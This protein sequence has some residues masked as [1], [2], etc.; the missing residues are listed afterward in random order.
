[1]V[2]VASFTAVALSI[3]IIRAWAYAP[4]PNLHPIE[5]YANQQSVKPGEI[6][7]F[8]ASLP[9]NTD[10]SQRTTYTVQYFRY[11]AAGNEQPTSVLGP[12]QQT[13]GINQAYTPSAYLY[14]AAWTPSFDLSIPTDWPSGIYAAQLTDTAETNPELKTAWVTFIVRSSSGS[15]KP[16]AF[17]AGT[18]TYHAY[19]FWPGEAGNDDS[20]SFYANCSGQNARMEVSFLRPAPSAMPVSTFANC[21]PVDQNVSYARNNWKYLENVRT[22]HLAAADV[23]IARWLEKHQYGYSMLTDWDI[24]QDYAADKK[25]D[26]LNPAVT[27]VLIIGS[28][29]EYW[30]Q[31]MYDALTQYVD[32]GGNLVVLGGNT[33]YWRVALS[34]DPATGNRTIEKGANWSSADK[35]KLL[36]IG[37]YNG[38]HSYCYSNLGQFSTS[39]WAYTTPQA[40][41]TGVYMGGSGEMKTPANECTSTGNRATAIGWEL[42]YANL[43][44]ARN[45]VRLAGLDAVQDKSDVFYFQRPSAGSVFV[46][47]SITFGQSLMYDANNGGVMTKL[48]QNILARMNKRTFSDFTAADPGFPNSAGK[49]DLLVRRPNEDALRIYRGLGNDNVLPGGQVLAQTGW[50]GYNLLLPIGD[51]DSDG[52]ADVLA[53]DTSGNMRLHRGNGAGGF[54]AN[55][56]QIIDTGWGTGTFNSIVAP[57]DWNGDGHPDLLARKLDGSLHLYRG[58]GKGGFY[59]GG[60]QIATGMNGLTLVAPGDFDYNASGSLVRTPGKPDLIGRVDATGDLRLYHGNGQGFAGAYDVINRGWNGITLISAGDFSGD[61]HPD[62]LGCV[63]GTSE[64]RVYHGTGGNSSI[65]GYLQAGYASLGS[66]WTCNTSLFAGV[67]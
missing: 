43:R 39:H 3:G 21:G 34:T 5:G 61:T 1:M 14:G 67:W 28:H 33:L 17:L 26:M 59:L 20:G 46:A 32:K 23:H 48:L 60:Q 2:F 18:N 19:N 31:P 57:G 27:P 22:D 13:N 64:M 45:W 50:A 38:L 36:G 10:G 42:D 7:T 8:Y 53:R 56:G 24:D 55:T 25:F 35:E 44:F 51:F 47:G 62:I 29:N 40:V 54:E 65:T 4:D 37:S 52:D 9:R 66:G 11:G 6:L 49:P 16:I 63:P 58:N 15:E 30:S 12:L 41:P